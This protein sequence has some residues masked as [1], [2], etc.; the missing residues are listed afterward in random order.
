M[1]L[2]F[3]IGDQEA[4]SSSG[5]GEVVQDTEQNNVDKQIIANIDNTDHAQHNLYVVCLTLDGLKVTRGILIGL[6]L[7]GLKRNEIYLP[8]C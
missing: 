2:S 8:F 1:G 5:D 6:T 3:L 4:S 7:D